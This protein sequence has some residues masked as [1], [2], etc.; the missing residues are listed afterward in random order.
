MRIPAMCPALCLIV[1][2]LL[3][4]RPALGQSSDKPARTP[5]GSEQVLRDIFNEV[6]LLRVERL[7]TSVSNYRSQILLRR[8]KV[9]QDQV[10]QLT[11]E[12]NNIQD[13]IASIRG[14]R[15]TGKGSLEDLVKKKDLGVVA[16][17]VVNAMALE[18]ETLQQREEDLLTR[19]SQVSL[20]LDRAKAKLAELDTRLNE[21]ER[22]MVAPSVGDDVKPARRRR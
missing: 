20:E 3:A 11:R 5:S 12:M 8:I 9:E 18:L 4:P 19:Q 14:Q 17:E 13:R 16:P 7:R 2:V 15:T 21:I 1:L 10:A 22:E 6:H